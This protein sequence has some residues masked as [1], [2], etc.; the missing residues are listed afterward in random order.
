MQMIVVRKLT[1]LKMVPNPDRT[2]RMI[3]TSPAIPG[4]FTELAQRR[5]R[6]PADPLRPGRSEEAGQPDQPAE[7]KKSL[8]PD[9]ESRERDSR[10]ADLQ[11][12]S[13]FA[14]PTNGGVP[15]N[16]SMI[17]PRMVNNSL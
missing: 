1:P 7:G 10:R 14:N 13:S 16:S 11:R 2:G 9:V 12:H 4:E 8:A 5:V 3:H 6:I 17:V 15:N